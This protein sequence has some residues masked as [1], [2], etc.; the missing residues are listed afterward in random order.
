MV[1]NNKKIL[2]AITGG[3]AC[4]KSAELARKLIVQGAELQVVM[5]EG[6]QQFISPMTFVA[7]TGK[8][9]RTELF[10]SEAEI[11]MGH[12]ELAKWAD[13]ILIAPATANTIAK[14][15]HGFADDLLSTLC[16]ATNAQLFIAPAMN[17]A[18]WH[19]PVTQNNIAALN[20]LGYTIL[21]PA[22]GA[23]A[24]GD[25]GYGRMLEVDQI[26]A[27]LL[28]VNSHFNP[29]ILTGK[30]VLITAGP[31]QEAID[32]VRFISNKSSGKM[33]YALAQIAKQLGLEVTLISGPVK[34]EPP[35]GIKF[36]G[37]ISTQEMFDA[38]RCYLP[39]CDIFI[40]CAAVADFRCEKQAAHKIK[41]TGESSFTLKFIQ[42]PDILAYVAEQSSKPLTIGFAAETENLI[43]NAKQKLRK[44]GLDVII[45][46]DVSHLETGFDSDDNSGFII[47]DNSQ[48][49]LLKANKLKIAEQ[50][51]QFITKK[52]FS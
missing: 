36:I 2:L 47:T 7:L 43:E 46:N 18:M 11:G 5:T 37:V 12:I 48:I 45:A 31:T 24:C 6:A 17:Q 42:N 13:I 38:V 8:K 40:G 28:A 21:G 30:R 35:S 50:I 26:L 10:D 15:A 27:E 29:G 34:I 23:Q 32:P 20:K 25:M 52:F 44:K 16:L 33:G 14:L 22:E 41:K 9:V 1:L 49:E 39:K 4:Y 3:I 51:F 19:H